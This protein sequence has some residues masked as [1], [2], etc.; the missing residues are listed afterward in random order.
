MAKNSSIPRLSIVVPV[1]VD[2]EAFEE[3][4]LTVLENRPAGSEILVAH[5]GRYQDPFDL[6]DEVRFVTTPSD[7]LI[8]QVAHGTRQARG[9]FVH[10]L[11]SGLLATRDWADSALGQ[12][13]R[14][15]TAVVAP[16]IRHEQAIVAAGWRDTPRRLF[17]PIAAGQR[18]IDRGDAN[19]VLGAYLQASFWRRD[20][21]RSVLAAFESDDVTDTNYAY[22]RLLIAS[23][24]SCS[25]AT[26]CEVLAP[27][28]AAFSAHS[29]Y[30]QAKRLW[31]IKKSID[32]ATRP[33]S[34][35]Q[36][37]PEIF[38]P[39]GFAEKLGQINGA[40]LVA[41]MRARLQIELVAVPG[42]QPTV[43]K[44]PRSGQRE[45]TRRAA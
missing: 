29:S 21:L 18:S 11:A 22:G 26:S 27:N 6:A 24:W 15:Q 5:D 16:V 30:S 31:A 14:Q 20:V 3:T 12:F 43:V 17:Q 2:T 41:S 28:H 10:V 9:R 35:L 45:K 37:L 40:S 44:M 4:L 19:G 39:T 36:L 32:P 42:D 33:V 13:E 23:G 1:G 7:S 25:L 34:W 8:D 38:R